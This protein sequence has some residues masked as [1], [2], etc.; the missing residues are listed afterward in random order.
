MGLTI[1]NT[2]T[3]QLLNILNRTSSEQSLSLERLTTGKRINRG[4]DDPAGLIALQNLG[5]E[6]TAVDAALGNGQRANSLLGVADGAFNE[7]NSLLSQIESLAAQSTNSSGISAAELAANQAQIDQA[8]NSI[9][10]IV[11]NTTFN[12]LKLLDGQQSV[13]YTL[14][15]TAN[16][17]VSD[18]R[19]YSRRSN[20][21]SDTLTLNVTTAAQVASA[22][23]ANTASVSAASISIAGKNGTT[24]ITIGDG[25]A[26]TSVRDKIIAA[27]GETGVSAR[28]SGNVLVGVTRDYGTAAFLTVSRLSGDSDFQNVSYTKGADAVVTVNGASVTGDGL[29]ISFNSNGVS[30]EFTLTST[31]NAAGSAGVITVSGGGATFQ[32]GTG[33][34][35]Q[36]TAGL[37]SL[38]SHKL[39]DTATG[40]L[41]QLKS[42]GANSLS[43]SATNALSIARKAISQVATAQGRLGGFQKY[44]VQSTM[45]SLNAT[46]KSLEEAR[47]AIGDVDFAVE[48]A[49]LNRQNV[50]L[51]SA[52]GL[53][54]LAG[55]QTSQILS[56]LR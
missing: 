24:T 11:N 44:V 46:K 51:Q 32:L 1:T 43:S 19:L 27:A 29:Q 10:R 33:S 15:S 48:S 6:L 39:G 4:S 9:D 38:A 40:Y 36:V 35:T 26:L 28:V 54:G 3:L 22:T 45:N 55:Q 18:V 16:T 49:N 14:D 53:L 41:N 30:G 52:I 17:D 37:E 2:N 12:G 42:G 47:S 20:S 34:N 5:A 31:G 7:V 23:I 13:R 56:L 25:E 50:L 21:S 8:I